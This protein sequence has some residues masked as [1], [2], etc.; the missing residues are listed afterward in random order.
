MNSKNIV[1]LFGVT[2]VFVGILGFIDNPIVS[3]SGFFAVNASHNMVH[4]VLG[5]AFVLGAFLQ[6]GHENQVLL[7]FGLGGLVV[8]LIGFLTPGDVILGFIHV[9]AADH[10][11][12]LVLG[13][14]V[15][16]SGLIFKN[17][18]HSNN[19]ENAQ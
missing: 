17:S 16:L 4:I 8:T 19:I 3:D 9:N 11:L 2:F 15:L 18:P 6:K 12:H 5:L 1:I 14:V 13:M 10:W 7:F